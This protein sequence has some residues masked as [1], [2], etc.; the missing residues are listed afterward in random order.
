MVAFSENPDKVFNSIHSEADV[1]H[2]IAERIVY[3]TNQASYEP[4]KFD[5]SLVQN[6]ENSESLDIAK[7][8]SESEVKTEIQNIAENIEV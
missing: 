5:T 8:K 7:V 4:V 2:L 3:A 1:N 6:L